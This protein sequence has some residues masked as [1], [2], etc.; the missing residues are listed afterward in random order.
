MR[1]A[2]ERRA[3]RRRTR[4]SGVIERRRRRRRGGSVGQRRAAASPRRG[5]RRRSTDRARTTK[6]SGIARDGAQVAGADERLPG[7]RRRA[8]ALRDT[9]R[10]PGA[11]RRSRPCASSCRSRRARVL[12]HPV[13]LAGLG[14]APEQR[15]RRA[16]AGRPAPASSA[17]SGFRN[18]AAPGHRA[19]SLEPV[20]GAPCSRCMRPEVDEADVLH[21]LPLRR[22]RL[23]G[24]SAAA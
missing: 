4:G 2:D 12:A 23:R 22:R 3:P 17:A 16:R 19:A 10:R 15:P 5:R 11:A 20:G 8:A 9:L 13:V 7:H 18:Q 21:V 1:Q 6:P 14:D 24:P